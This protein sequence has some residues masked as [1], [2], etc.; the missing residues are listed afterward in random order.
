MTAQLQECLRLN[1]TSARSRGLHR[2]N[3]CCCPWRTLGGRGRRSQESTLLPARVGHACA[4]SVPRSSR[5]NLRET[6][7]TDAVDALR[8]VCRA[9]GVSGRASDFLQDALPP[10]PRIQGQVFPKRKVAV[11]H[12]P[13]GGKGNKRALACRSAW[14]H[15]ALAGQDRWLLRGTRAHDWCISTDVEQEA[16]RH[17]GVAS[18]ESKKVDLDTGM[19]T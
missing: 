7:V 19:C 2:H 5:A 1:S 17:A 16:S 14:P 12:E 8:S 4:H 3:V 10:H 15:V 6:L 9:D 18:C 13:G 11:L